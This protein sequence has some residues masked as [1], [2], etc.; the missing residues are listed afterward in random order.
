MLR[1]Y[2]SIH[3][4]E[5]APNGQHIAALLRRNWVA[6]RINI[7]NVTTGKRVRLTR[8]RK[9][10]AFSMS[11]QNLIGIL[12]YHS[13]YVAPKVQFFDR[14]ASPVA[15]FKLPTSERFPTWTYRLKSS[16]SGSLVAVVMYECV[17]IKPVHE[18]GDKYQSIP[19][20]GF[21][22]SIED[23]LLSDTEIAIL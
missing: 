1:S 20:S 19:N 8:Y 16:P 12:L 17:Y 18:Q 6:K 5:I 10:C 4:V 14:T 21:R 2:P 3:Q 9:I 13:I 23:V 7:Y 15:T 22:R 11:D